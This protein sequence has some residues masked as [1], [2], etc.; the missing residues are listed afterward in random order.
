MDVWRSWSPAIPNSS[1]RKLHLPF[2]CWSLRDQVVPFSLFCSV[3]GWSDW[4]HGHSRTTNYSIWYWYVKFLPSWRPNLWCVWVTWPS[5][6]MNIWRHTLE[7]CML[8]VIKDKGPILLTDYFHRNYFS[9]VED[10]VGTDVSKVVGI[11]IFSRWTNT[12][13]ILH[14]C[15]PGHHKH[16]IART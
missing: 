12:L 6:H 2:Y 10:V 7:S 3:C 13:F 14:P 4:S 5:T 15:T 16:H 11:T 9:I 1:W 8:T